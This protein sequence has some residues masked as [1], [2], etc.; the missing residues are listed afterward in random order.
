MN[1]QGTPRLPNG[2]AQIA[3]LGI[4]YAV[5]TMSLCYPTYYRYGNLP[6]TLLN[7]ERGKVC[8]SSQNR[9]ST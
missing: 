8:F 6:I 5:A 9:G 4:S 7:C 1:A 2:I 3:D